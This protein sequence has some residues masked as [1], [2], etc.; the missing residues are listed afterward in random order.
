MSLGPMKH[1]LAILHSPCHLN[2]WGGGGL[3]PWQ[4]EATPRGDGEIIL[5]QVLKQSS[6]IS[7]LILY[8]AL[9]ENIQSVK[10]FT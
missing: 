8:A 4:M 1:P 10:L 7:A 6:F 9:T 3:L 5:S 2:G